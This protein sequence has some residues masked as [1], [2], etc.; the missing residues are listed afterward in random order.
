MSTITF[1]NQGTGFMAA[2]KQK[3]DAYFKANNTT[4]YGNSAL[5]G[6]SFVI[7]SMFVAL[8]VWLVF[9]TPQNAGFAL[10]LSCLFGVSMA[11]I[12]FNIMHD[13]S[14][15]SYSSNPKVNTIMAYSLNFL[16]G[17]AY[18][19]KQKHVVNH[20]TYTNVEGMDDDLDAGMFFRFHHGQK[21]RG[22]HK[23][24]HI[25]WVFLYGGLYFMW[26]ISKDTKKFLNQRISPNSPKFKF[27]VGQRILFVASKIVHLLLFIGLPFYY[28]KAH[29]SYSYLQIFFGYFIACFL[30]GWI[31]SVVFQMAHV[32]D[33]TE[34]VTP[35]YTNDK[36][37]IENEWAIHQVKTTSDFATDS[38]FLTWALGGLNFQVE[39]HL[40]PRISHV[41]YPAIN[42]IVRETCAEYGIPFLEHKT[43]LDAIKS[44]VKHLKFMGSAPELQP[45]FAH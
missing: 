17:D 16:G 36:E 10:L 3:T 45:A 32:V 15:D 30:L 21:K 25:Y 8:Y 11:L 19:W 13:G 33:H 18:F 34:F 14:H 2:L 22:F 28:I 20:H 29:T 12:G 7:I 4:P 41:H 26:I 23:F 40:F 5:I 37:V 24:Q 43:F 9:F 44:H 27:T 35:T 38:A 31:L 42:K 1:Q 39:H 6:K